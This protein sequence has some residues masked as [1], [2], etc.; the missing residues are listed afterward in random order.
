MAWGAIAMKALWTSLRQ[1]PIAL[2]GHAFVAF[3][4]AWTTTDALSH[5]FGWAA[6][7]S[8]EWFW[9]IIGGSL[10]YAIYSIWRPARVVIAVP[11]SNVSVEIAFGDIFEQDGVVAIPVNEFFD[12]EIGL[13]VSAKSL[14][15]V[16]LQQC[17][18]GHADAFDRQLA[19]T[20]GGK[21]VEVVARKQG[22]DQRF[23]IGTCA[24][25]EAAGRH[26]LAFAFT[27]TDI[28]TF[29]ASADVP[30]MFASLAGLWKAARAELGGEALNLPLVGSGLSGVALPARELLNIIILSFLDETKRQVITHNLR[31]VLTWDRLSEVDLREI[32]KLWEKA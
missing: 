3:S 6:L 30:Q 26:F 4:V 25:I 23:K 17:F 1:H 9:A 8:T 28:A 24:A 10:A 16:F 29:K 21:A 2:V 22:K 11:M 20:L 13:P 19:A 14:H 31:I 7:K 27:H 12:S 18:G 15:G 5:F 32:K